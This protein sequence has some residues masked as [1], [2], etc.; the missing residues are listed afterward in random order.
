MFHKWPQD[1]TLNMDTLNM[2]TQKE[3]EDNGF[4]KVAIAELARFCYNFTAAI[5]IPNGKLK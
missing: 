4:E 2:D 5:L 3:E 1:L